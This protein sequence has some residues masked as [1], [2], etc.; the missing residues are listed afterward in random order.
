MTEISIELH[1]AVAHYESLLRNLSEQ[2]FSQRPAP[3][4][5]SKKEELGH[6]I[7]SAQNNLRRFIVCRYENNPRIVYRQ[8]EWVAASGYHEF[9][10]EDLIQLWALLNKQICSVLESFP[11]ELKSKTCDTG[12]EKTELKTIEWLAEDYLPH[13]KHHLHHLLELE[14]VNYQSL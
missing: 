11:E 7:D 12:H 1:N 6:L 13:M 5:W 3:G 2:Q 4:K 8:E 10:S 14:E 9:A